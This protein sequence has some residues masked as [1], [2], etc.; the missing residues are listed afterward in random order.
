MN[1]REKKKSKISPDQQIHLQKLFKKIV[2]FKKEKN[3]NTSILKKN[4][5]DFFLLIE[6]RNEI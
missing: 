5:L 1:I 2:K 4:H 3:Y 6:R